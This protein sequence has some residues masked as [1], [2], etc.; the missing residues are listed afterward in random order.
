[1]KDKSIK[2]GKTLIMGVGN[3][4]LQDEGVGVHAVRVLQ[5]TDLPDNVKVIDVGTAFLEAIPFLERSDRV[6]V[7]DAMMAQGEPGTI[8]RVPLENCARNERIDSMHGFSIF[9]LIDLTEAKYEKD[10]VVLGVEPS[11]LDWGTE[12]SPSVKD[13]MPHLIEAVLE[14]IACCINENECFY[15]S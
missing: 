4:L 11:K 9:N 1:M 8:Y 7:I 5:N 15:K 2:T 13:S 14:E 10:I 6:I 3:L 12:L